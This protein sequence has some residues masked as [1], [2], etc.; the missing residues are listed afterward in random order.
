[1]T[2]SEK[3]KERAMLVFPCPNEYEQRRLAEL[4]F[5][6]ACNWKD[7]QF[8]EY[9]EK[10]REEIVSARGRCPDDFE[11]GINHGEELAIKQIIIELFGE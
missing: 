1:M 2:N 9:L 10:K 4:A 11:Q 7:Q 5:I 8:K 3:A 6:D